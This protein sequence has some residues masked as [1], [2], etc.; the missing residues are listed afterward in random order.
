MYIGVQHIFASILHAK[1]C[2][3]N[4]LR[5]AL[6]S[7]GF[8][9]L[10]NV[11]AHQSS[12]S[13]DVDYFDHITLF[14]QGRIT[15]FAQMPIRVYISPVL[16]DSPYLPEI[17]YAMQAWHNA[18]DGNIRFE[19]IDVPQDADI[20][21]SWGYTGFLA[22]FQDTRLGSAELTRLKDSVQIGTFSNGLDVGPITAVE[23]RETEAEHE[24]SFTVEVI[25][26][27]EGYGTVGE[28]SQEEMRTVCVH[29]F[30][31]A[32]GLWGHS[33]HPG[34]I[35]FPTATAQQPSDRDIATLRKLYN[36]PLNAPQHDVAIKVLKT[37]IEQKPYADPQMQLRTH[38]LLG[39]IYFDKGDIPAAIATFQTCRELNSKFQPAVEKL[40][41]IYHET[42]KTDQAIALVEERV[43]EK[44][45]PADYN[46]LGIFY[47][48]KKED[49]KA[50]QAF[51]KALHIAPYH[52]AARRNLHQLLRAEGFK[53]LAAEDFDTATTTFERVLQM[54]PLD[55]P[56]YQLMGNGYA[57]AGQFETAIAYYQ[58]AIDINPVD[59][60]TRQN[61]AQ[62]YN[63]YG[64]TLRNREE[65]DEA[66]EAYRNALR[67]MPTLH[68]ARTNLSDA[69]TRKATAHSQA[70]ELDEA[71]QV[72]L[73]LQK[74]H[75]HEMHIRNLLGELYLKKGD[76]AE[77]LSAFQHVYN[78]NPKA[79]HALHNLIAAYHHYARS[80]SDAED[81]VT[82]IQLLEEALRLASTDLNLR[83]SLAN[84]HQGAGD[85]ERASIELSRVLAQS[86]ENPQAKEEQ[87]NLRIRHGNALMRQRQYAAALAEFEAIPESKRDI[88]IYNTIGY[89]RLVQ[90]EHEKAFTAFETVLEKDPINVPAFRNLLSLESQLI[91]RRSDKIRDDT[92]VKVRCGLAIGLMKRKQ[93]TAAMQRY[94]LALKSKSEMLDP[95]LIETGQWLAN[96]FQQYGDTENRELVLRWIKERSKKRF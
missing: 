41:Q 69:F 76:Y 65:W 44:P 74:L 46:T 45:S 8:I 83:L 52:K 13:S 59:A 82:A 90:G 85:Y 70:G 56:T 20:R 67:L 42:G 9:L 35:C 10:N 14:S 15:R 43:A 32:I 28:L 93:P 50:V 1:T 39:A 49:E 38:Y 17:R 68:I 77:A 53:A 47:Y 81:Y 21:V 3:K 37:E 84:A 24:I 61:L 64:V 88:Q 30:G 71:V 66:I 80:L 54:E 55:A 91:R 92:L 48:E 22:N 96:Q 94:Q 95:L 89:L 86:P 12:P 4:V 72:Y 73:E 87:V 25:L 34:D 23:D 5:V 2:A 63:N 79:D 26:M 33:P 62:C 7:L 19:E 11:V 18:S 75:P 36:T 57:R 29:E 78:A 27:L 60:L 58:K 16:K 40:I 51:E 31:H 6:V